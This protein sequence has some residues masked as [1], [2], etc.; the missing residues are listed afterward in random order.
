M[1]WFWKARPVPPP[2]VAQQAFVRQPN[3]MQELPPPAST[4]AARMDPRTRGRNIGIGLRYFAHPSRAHILRRAAASVPLVF[5]EI[6]R[7]LRDIGVKEAKDYQT[8]TSLRLY[9]M[10]RKRLETSNRIGRSE[11]MVA[12]AYKFEREFNEKHKITSL[13]SNINQ[14][15][16]AI[17]QAD[18]VLAMFPNSD[19]QT[20]RQA[21]AREV[22][23][24]EVQREL[25]SIRRS[26]NPIQSSKREQKQEQVRREKHLK[27]ELESQRELQSLRR[28]V[29]GPFQIPES[30]AN[31]ARRE[32]KQK[33]VRREMYLKIE[34]LRRPLLGPFQK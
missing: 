21:G 6:A 25:Q 31:R 24:D 34:P 27:I 10:L 14:A 8:P 4:V 7:Q 29:Q 28:Q 9:A 17:R 1:P 18:Q 3:V 26:Q 32:Q 16:N 23:N 11:L 22:S 33:Q 5:P 13:Q 2:P 15:R 19:S 12:R 20:A 30:S